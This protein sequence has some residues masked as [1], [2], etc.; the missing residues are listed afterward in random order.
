MQVGTLKVGV[1]HV[2]PLQLGASFMTSTIKVLAESQLHSPTSDAQTD[3]NRW[4]NCVPTCIDMATSAVT[5]TPLRGADWWKDRAYGEAY[6]G[7]TAASAFVDLAAQCGAALTAIDNADNAV[8]ITAIHAHIAAGHPVIATEPDPYAPPGI[9]GWSHVLLF[10][11][12]SPGELSVIDPFYG[13]IIT[14]KDEDWQN[15]LE[16]HEVWGISA[17]KGD[18]TVAN[19]NIPTGW[20]LSKDKKSLTATNGVEVVMGFAQHIL[21]HT[22]DS[23]NVPLAK[24]QGDGH[25]GTEQL[26]MDN[27]LRWNPKDGVTVGNL[28][29]VVIENEAQ[30]AHLIKVQD[31]Y[32][33]M[34]AELQSKVQAVQNGIPPHV[35]ASLVSALH[36]AA[37]FV[38]AVQAVLNV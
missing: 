28:G 1:A 19:T 22:W 8:L 35:V 17:M 27:V 29:T 38:Q 12:E 18:F 24:E 20:S 26:F 33:A 6:I 10:Y 37:D 34:I 36:S 30:I 14:K 21:S 31:E 16:F 25:G 7:G 23:A 5:G 11:A 13:Q 3:E 9:T 15:I 2:R 4:Y 32:K